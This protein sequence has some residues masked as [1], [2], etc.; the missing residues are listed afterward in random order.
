MASAITYHPPLAPTEIQRQIPSV[1]AVCGKVARTALCGGREVTCVPTATAWHNGRTNK[2]SIVAPCPRDRGQH[3]RWDAWARRACKLMEHVSSSRLA[4]L[5]PRVDGRGQARGHGATMARCIHRHCARRLCPPYKSS[6]AFSR[7]VAFLAGVFCAR[8]R[9]KPRR[10]PHTANTI[11]GNHG[12]AAV[13]ATISEAIDAMSV[14][15]M[16]PTARLIG[17]KS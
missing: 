17:K 14:W 4:R 1:G 3:A 6:D 15:P 12:N 11:T 7:Y 8:H 2:W 5:C 10:A 16:S 9:R 13:R